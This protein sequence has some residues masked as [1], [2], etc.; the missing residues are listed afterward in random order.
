[1]QTNFETLKKQ[2]AENPTVANISSTITQWGQNVATAVAPATDAIKTNYDDLTN[3]TN[4]LIEERQRAR[5]SST[6]E[7]HTQEHPQY[8]APP[9]PPKNPQPDP[10]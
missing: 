1:M 3:Q 9:I 8:E 10:Q 2:A 4:Q 5:S 6:G 7:A